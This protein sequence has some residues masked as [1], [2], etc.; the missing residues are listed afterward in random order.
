MV[1]LGKLAVVIEPSLKARDAQRV[2]SEFVGHCCQTDLCSVPLDTKLTA[3]GNNLRVG[4]MG[5]DFASDMV[6]QTPN[7]L[8][9]RL[10]L[11]RSPS[12]VDTCLLVVSD[13]HDR[14][15]PKSIVGLTVS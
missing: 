10:A 12:G 11:R 2:G 9:S 14:D 15:A 3:D 8:A 1:T 7:D 13:A 6:F 5:K 4:Q